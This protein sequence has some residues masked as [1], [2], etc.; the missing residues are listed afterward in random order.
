[1]SAEPELPW[2]EEQIK[3]DTVGKK[4]VISWLQEHA[5]FAVR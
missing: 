2:T 1:M 4:D 3:A 5:S